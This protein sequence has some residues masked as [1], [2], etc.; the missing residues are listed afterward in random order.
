VARYYSVFHEE[1]KKEKPCCYLTEDDELVVIDREATA[2]LLGYDRWAA[3][4]EF[5]SHYQFERVLGGG[6]GCSWSVYQHKHFC[7]DGADLHLIKRNDE[8][9]RCS[10]TRKIRWFCDCGDQDEGFAACGGGICPK[11]GIVKAY[12]KLGCEPSE[13]GKPPCGNAIPRQQLGRL[14]GEAFSKNHTSREIHKFF[15]FESQDLRNVLIA[16]SPY[17]PSTVQMWHDR[18]LEIDHIISLRYLREHLGVFVTKDGDKKEPTLWA[19]MASCLLNLQ[20]LLRYLNGLKSD[21]VADE[22]LKGIER[23]YKVLMRAVALTD[24]SGDGRWICPHPLKKQKK[25]E[26]K[27]YVNIDIL[28]QLLKEDVAKNGGEIGCEK[29]PRY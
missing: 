2:K 28:C 18:L 26:E 24:P 20:L 8:N 19:L 12:C 14:L 21:K 1:T 13:E 23:R 25:G 10:R 9:W 5:F 11:S 17:G 3:V 4:L 16:G 29:L 6:L 22:T 15:G 7:A 27:V